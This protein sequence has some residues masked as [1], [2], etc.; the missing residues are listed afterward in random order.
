VRVERAKSILATTDL[1]MPEVAMRSGFCSAPRFSDMF[2][3]ETG[4]TPGSY[5]RT[6]RTR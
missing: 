1:S 3:R 2:R 5:R 4:T 6:F